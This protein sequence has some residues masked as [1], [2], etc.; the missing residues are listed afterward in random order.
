MWN[1]R[2][3]MKEAESNQTLNKGKNR[4]MDAILWWVLNAY[5]EYEPWISLGLH[6]DHF[7]AERHREV[8]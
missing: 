7:Q 3:N 4:R 6:I 1:E 8:S 5:Y 2:T